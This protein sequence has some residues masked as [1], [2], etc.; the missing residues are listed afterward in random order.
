MFWKSQPQG[1]LHLTLSHWSGSC[2]RAT[3]PP[4]GPWGGEKKRKQTRGP[5][6]DSLPPPTPP[7]L[8]CPLPFLTKI[9]SLFSFVPL[10]M[11]RENTLLVKVSNCKPESAVLLT[12]S[13][14]KLCQRTHT[15]TKSAPCGCP[16][17]PK[18]THK[19]QTDLKPC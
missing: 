6:A 2:L 11:I 15:E 3:Y 16:R 9:L 1:L 5:K 13:A 12:G 8:R 10:K 19:M 4:S 18:L 17:E 7:R 14:R